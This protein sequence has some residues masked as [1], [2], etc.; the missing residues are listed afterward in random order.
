MSSANLREEKKGSVSEMEKSHQKQIDSW[1]AKKKQRNGNDE[2][3][4]HLQFLNMFQE[5]IKKRERK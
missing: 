1:E 5:R 3:F 2:K 4:K